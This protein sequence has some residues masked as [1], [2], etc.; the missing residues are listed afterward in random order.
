MEFLANSS[1]RTARRRVKQR[2][3][4]RAEELLRAAFPGLR[5]S[6]LVTRA[7]RYTGR[8]EK[9]VLNWL[10]HVHDMK[11]DDAAT[12]LPLIAFEKAL[13]ILYPKD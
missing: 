2:D 1:S 12:L 4:N 13:Q 8:S 3:R 10:E 11:L 9:T 6:E 7:A 5:K